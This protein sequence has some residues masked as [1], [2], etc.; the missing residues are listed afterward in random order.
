MIT[1]T[2]STVLSIFFGRDHV[3]VNLGV[4]EVLQAVKPESISDFAAAALAV[5]VGDIRLLSGACFNEGSP[6]L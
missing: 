6:G 4:T 5:L 3:T 1:Q 2:A